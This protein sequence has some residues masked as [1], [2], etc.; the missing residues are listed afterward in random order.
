MPVEERICPFCMKPIINSGLKYYV[1]IKD[2]GSLEKTDSP[3]RKMFAKEIKACR[4]N[5]LYKQF[6]MERLAEEKIGTEE[7]NQR[8]VVSEQDLKS[9]MTGAAAA[10]RPA[11]VLV[12]PEDPAG[13]GL[14]SDGRTTQGLVN[15]NRKKERQT[16]AEKEEAQFGK[17]EKVRIEW[18]HQERQFKIY[19]DNKLAAD[20]QVVCNHCWNVLPPQIYQTDMKV[21]YI[22]LVAGIGVGKSCL[23]LSWLRSVETNN[24]DEGLNN[25][26]DRYRFISLMSYDMS[27]PKVYEEMADKF[28]NRDICPKKTDPTFVPPA[29]FEATRVKDDKKVL[30][31]IY[32]AAGEVL[33]RFKEK[34]QVDTLMMHLKST[35]AI[36]Y[37]VDPEDVGMP[38]KHISS[39]YSELQTK[40]WEK[41]DALFGSEIMDPQRQS[42]EEARL[43]A[44]RTLAEIIQARLDENVQ[45]GREA[46]RSKNDEAAARA[47]RNYMHKDQMQGRGADFRSQTGGKKRI[48]ALAMSKSDSFDPEYIKKYPNLLVGSAGKKGNERFGFEGARRVEVSE[49]LSGFYN[50]DKFND[51]FEAHQ[52]FV[53][54][55]LGC[56]ARPD[57]LG[58]ETILAG[59]YQ[60]FRIEEPIHWILDMLLA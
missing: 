39:K 54:S 1:R 44:S 48:L 59:E 19:Q 8:L 46:M 29:F 34:D 57:M 7:M 38:T 23:F 53:L 42:D 26:P 33:T 49:F 16:A 35:D 52:E 15:A 55:S 22:G 32:D 51:Y 36:V 17:E 47:L 21:I 3:L 40:I 27:F 6:W 43:V 13:T 2:S 9:M 12:H 4:E 25:W 31:C 28:E 41:D 45:S 20:T 50:L 11:P 14:V 58:K 60:P 37:L 30:L 56:E 5:N 10:A 18:F 24:P